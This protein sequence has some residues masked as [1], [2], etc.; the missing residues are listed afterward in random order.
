M[1]AQLR[2]Q[3][4]R[5]RKARKLAD[6]LRR[7]SITS[8][9]ARRM[10]PREWWHVAQLA[11]CN[12]PNSEATRNAVYSLL[13]NPGSSWTSWD[14][15]TDVPCFFRTCDGTLRWAE[16]GY[17]PGYRICD[18]CGRHYQLARATMEGGRFAIRPN[19]RRSPVLPDGRVS[20][21]V[22]YGDRV[23]T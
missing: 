7:A 22:P 3:E 15:I 13:D 1:S 11:G 5:A 6:E 4:A 16:N 14:E 12:P 8:D 23:S 18:K 9:L 20:F 21:F 17:V 19:G 2:E 10:T